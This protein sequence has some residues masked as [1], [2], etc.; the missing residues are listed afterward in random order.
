MD[1]FLVTKKYIF[2]LSYVIEIIEPVKSR[3]I[4]NNGQIEQSR[5]TVIVM[6]I[7]EWCIRKHQHLVQILMKAVWV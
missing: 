7:N 4:E 2:T 5:Q 3:R 1:Y 6:K